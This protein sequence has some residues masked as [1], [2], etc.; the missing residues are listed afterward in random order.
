MAA[1]SSRE[2]VFHTIAREP[3]DRPPISLWM[4]FP[5]CDWEPDK[6][7][8]ESV[9]FHREL[10]LDLMKLTP[11]GLYG[12]VDWGCKLSRPK[13]RY[14]VPRVID[15]PIKE[16]KDWKKLRYISPDEGEYG[17]QLRVVKLIAENIE[18]PLI[19]TIFSPLTTARKLA[20]DLVFTHMRE[21]PEELHAGLEVI[22]ETTRDFLLAVLE[23]GADAVSYTHL[24]LPTKA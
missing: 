9:N 5:Y 20:G 10:R 22:T 3:L 6:F 7:V 19:E 18:E 4:H 1:L 8:N 11:P 16:P 24:T 21:A 14:E 23:A 15:F 17:K 13:Q 12:C 2:R